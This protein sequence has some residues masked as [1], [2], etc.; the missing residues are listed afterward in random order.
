MNSRL[1]M[2][3]PAYLLALA[4]LVFYP[5]GAAAQNGSVRGT[6]VDPQG[7]IVSGANIRLL[8]DNDQVAQAPTDARGE[9]RFDSLPE[10]RY[11]VEVTAAGFETRVTDYRSG[12]ALVWE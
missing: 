4:A 3:W 12:G 8:R 11:Q 2:R 5:S 1:R 6:V 9:F 7:A 10:G